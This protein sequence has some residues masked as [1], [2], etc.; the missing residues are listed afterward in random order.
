VKERKNPIDPRKED[1]IGKRE[2]RVPSARDDPLVFP[3]LLDGLTY[4]FDVFLSVVFVEVRG[5]HVCG[6]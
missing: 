1:K 2:R 6:G 3:T 4:T 5:F